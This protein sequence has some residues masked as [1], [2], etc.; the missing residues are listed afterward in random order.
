[1]PSCSNKSK[2]LWTDCGSNVIV[3]TRAIQLLLKLSDFEAIQ[4]D[5]ALQE[6]IA[7]GV[8]K[9]FASEQT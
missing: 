7:I 8:L 5:P 6:N 9:I 2:W 1:M 4:S 3:K